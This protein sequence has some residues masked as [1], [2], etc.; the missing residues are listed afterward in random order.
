MKIKINNIEFKANKPKARA[1]R[2]L[3]EFDET[4]NELPFNEYVDSHVEMIV[5]SF[6]NPNVTEDLLLDN[7]E[8]D[9]IMEIYRRLLVW[10]CE[11]LS[12]KLDKIPNEP[13]T[14]E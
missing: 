2:E 13:A 9:E 3:M 1:W 7:L 5:K 8:V 6:A 10:F 12:K 4:K 11:L 14:V